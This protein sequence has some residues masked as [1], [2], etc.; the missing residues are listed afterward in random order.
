MKNLEDAVAGRAAEIDALN[1][2]VANLMVAHAMFTGDVRPLTALREYA[3][4]AHKRMDEGG[5]S[6]IPAE[7]FEAQCEAFG[8]ILQNAFESDLPTR[9]WVQSAWQWLDERRYG[10]NLRLHKAIR[11]IADWPS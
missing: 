4:F 10:A 3:D 6:R 1:S 5:T 8:S 7:F 11:R 9:Y 2:P